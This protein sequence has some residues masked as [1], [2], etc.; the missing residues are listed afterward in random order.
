CGERPELDGDHRARA[1]EPDRLDGRGRVRGAAGAVLECL[2][3]AGPRRR[4]ARP[5]LNQFRLRAVKGAHPSIQQG[6]ELKRARRVLLAFL[7][8][9]VFAG[10]VQPSTAVAAQVRPA[11]EQPADSPARPMP[12]DPYKEWD[13]SSGVPD[14]GD[15]RFR[16]LVVDNAELAEDQ[17][18]RDAAT[19][20]LAAGT[21]AA[22][23]DFLNH[24][25]DEA[26]ARANARKAETA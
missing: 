5:R 20:A 16:Q 15:P 17:E 14:W 22:L 3:S 6:D 2:A 10:L 25:L 4:T 18:V 9:A 21:T 7:V 19:A 26:K 13:G 23:M 8:L 11:A 1:D 12:P 24:G